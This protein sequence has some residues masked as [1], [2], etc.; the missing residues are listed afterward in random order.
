MANILKT[1]VWQVDTVV[2]VVTTSLVIINSI[3]VRMNTAGAGSCIITTIN[4]Q[5][6][7]DIKTTST[8]TAVVYSRMLDFSFDGQSFNGLKK[9]VSVGVATIYIFIK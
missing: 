9:T 5:P 2:G 4:N 7:L 1:N 3:K 8:S 6:I